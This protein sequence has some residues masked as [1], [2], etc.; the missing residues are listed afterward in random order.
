MPDGT[1]GAL[2]KASL[3]IGVCLVAAVAG[4]FVEYFC[5]RTA[6]P[7]Y[8]VC[9]AGDTSS[10]EESTRC[11]TIHLYMKVPLIAVHLIPFILMPF[12]MWV[13]QEH[14][15]TLR[16]MGAKSPTQMVR[17]LSYIMVSI[18]GEVGWH[19]HQQWFYH[20]DFDI[21]NCFFYV[22]NTLGATYWAL[23]ARNRDTETSSFDVFLMLC[24]PLTIIAYGYGA[25]AT[26]QSMPGASKVPIYLIMTYQYV[27][28]SWRLFKL[29]N[30]DIRVGLFPVCSIG[31]NLFFVFLLSMNQGNTF[32]N[33][34]FHILHDAAGTE[35][36]VL[37]ITLL[38]WTHAKTFNRHAD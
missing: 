34:L 22:F 18:A 13:C 16:S 12:S 17:G 37:I 29:L 30:G 5:L 14:D 35:M 1:L 24:T 23:G 10:L 4:I 2:G 19:V 27:L 38:L 21:L 32:L 26:S 3:G 8:C 7:V 9:R 15:S 36:G 33:P 20:E 25:Y 28:L 31:V 6:S 11:L